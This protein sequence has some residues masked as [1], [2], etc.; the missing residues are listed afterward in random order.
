MNERIKS[1]NFK[2]N[3]IGLESYNAG[4]TVLAGT[5]KFHLLGI[6]NF[7]QIHNYF[8]LSFSSKIIFSQTAKEWSETCQIVK[9]NFG[10][11]FSQGYYTGIFLHVIWR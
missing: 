11:N 6:S 1:A 7:C 5:K 3:S 4:E 10:S 8:F 9:Y 2:A